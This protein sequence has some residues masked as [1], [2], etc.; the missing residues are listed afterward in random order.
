[1]RHIIMWKKI[2]IS[3]FT[4]H[5]QWF[6][7]LIFGSRRVNISI[8]HGNCLENCS[9]ASLFSPFCVSSG[10]FQWNLNHYSFTL[11]I[12]II[13]HWMLKVDQFNTPRSIVQLII[14]NA[15]FTET[16]F[17]Q[18]FIWI[19][20]QQNIQWHWKWLNLW[21]E[22]TRTFWAEFLASA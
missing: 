4:P 16:L 9:S 1:M 17:R 7:Q 22:L 10:W 2:I 6:P 11:L 15:S 20:A 13:N 8:K 5:S 21:R 19:L 18:I 14:N 12:D 3:L